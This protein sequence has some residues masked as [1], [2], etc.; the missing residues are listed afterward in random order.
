MLYA[1][2]SG[3][4]SPTEGGDHRRAVTETHAFERLRSG[5]GGSSMNFVAPAMVAAVNSHI[6]EFHVFQ[7]GLS[8][9]GI[10]ACLG[11]NMH[12]NTK[13]SKLQSLDHLSKSKLPKML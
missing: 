3:K 1:A 9:L 5:S 11:L 8:N 4:S 2:K 7:T 12:F 6:L 10:A 13:I